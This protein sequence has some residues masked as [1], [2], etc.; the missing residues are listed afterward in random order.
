MKWLRN[1]LKGASL[2][3]ALFVF[4]ACYGTPMD[5]WYEGGTA[6]LSFR[7]LDHVSG[8]PIE[9]VRVSYGINKQWVELGTTQED[10][11]VSVS[12]PYVRNVKGPDVRFQ[13]FDKPYQVKDTVFVDLRPREITVKLDRKNW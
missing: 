6:E 4:Q 3:G 8:K 5:P 11:L 12:L 9:G 7:V 13:S 2:T 1:L 10:G